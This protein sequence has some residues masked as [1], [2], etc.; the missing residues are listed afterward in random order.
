MSKESDEKRELLKL[1]QGIIEESDIIEQDV[2]EQPEEQTAVKKIDNFFY[3]NKWFVVVGVF[4]AALVAFFTYQIIT[5]EDPDLTV[6]L[7]IS[8]TDKAPGLYQKVNDIEL[9]LEQYCPDYDNNGYVHVADRK[10]ISLTLQRVLTASMYSQTLLSS[11]ARYS[12]V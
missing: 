8:D 9:A 10:Y 11:M 4:F 3:R 6:M 1:K 2:H 12:A 5:R 7:V